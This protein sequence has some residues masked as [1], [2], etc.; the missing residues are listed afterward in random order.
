MILVLCF[1]RSTFVV[2]QL[3]R[4]AHKLWPVI[5]NN[6]K[7]LRTKFFKHRNPMHSRRRSKHTHA[8]KHKHL[9]KDENHP[10]NEKTPKNEEHSK[11]TPHTKEAEHSKDTKSSEHKNTQKNEELPKDKKSSDKESTSNKDSTTNSNVE[12]HIITTIEPPSS[13]D[14]VA[15]HFVDRYFDN[16]NQNQED[17]DDN[18]SSDDENNSSD[19]NNPSSSDKPP[20]DESDNTNLSPFKK[21]PDNQKISSKIY[22]SKHFPFIDK[23]ESPKEKNV[24]LIKFKDEQNLFADK[25]FSA[26]KDFN[27]ESPSSNFLSNLLYSINN[28]DLYRT[29]SLVSDN[30]LPFISSELVDRLVKY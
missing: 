26:E 30:S 4:Q 7:S 21:S 17:D 27:I 22:F 24:G 11:D 1:F 28:D 15:R 3:I 19:N 6:I 12:E 16:Q 20:P 18:N 14:Y 13:E 5:R 8:P 29:H 10:N 25:T 2:K 9:P 23:N